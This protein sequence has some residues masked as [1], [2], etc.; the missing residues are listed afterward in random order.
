M[1]ILISMHVLMRNSNPSCTKIKFF[2]AIYNKYLFISPYAYINNLI[3]RN[4]ETHSDFIK[5]PYIY[6]TKRSGRV[7]PYVF[8]FMQRRVQL[9]QAAQ[10]RRDV[11]GSALFN[12]RCFAI[13]NTRIYAHNYAYRRR[14][15]SADRPLKNRIGRR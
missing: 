9:Q 2:N 11:F 5:C 8:A 6:N 12:P 10:G 7:L 3:Y 14:L 15:N 1:I 4:N 13:R